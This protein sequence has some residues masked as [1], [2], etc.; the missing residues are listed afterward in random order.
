MNGAGCGAYGA[1]GG[2]IT[3]VVLRIP[4]ELGK[5]GQS[6]SMPQLFFCAAAC[7]MLLVAPV[8]LLVGTI[9]AVV[10]GVLAP[11]GKLG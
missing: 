6:P 9:A 8:V 10:L 4:A 5:L 11:V 2:P 1:G 7:C 3:V